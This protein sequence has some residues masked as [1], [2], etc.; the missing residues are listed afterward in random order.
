MRKLALVIAGIG[1][2]FILNGCATQS[3]DPEQLRIYEQNND[4]L[5]PMNRTIFGF[6]MAVDKLV[7]KPAAQGYRA[8][9]PSPVRKGVNNFFNNLKQPVY[10]VNAL[11]QGEGKA[12]GQI[13]GRFAA[14]TFWGFLGVFDTASQM[15]IPVIKRDFGE[16]LAVWGMEYGGPYLVLPVL[17]P[18][19]PRDAVGIGVDSVLAPLDWA[20]RH[21]PWIVYGM[22]GIDGFRAREQALDFLDSLERSST[23]FYATMRSMYQ[24]NRR[25][26]INELLKNPDMPEAVPPYEFDF[27]DDFSDDE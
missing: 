10:F 23:D 9:V 17:G 27:P 8:V 19:N 3:V 13:A 24:Q 25:K 2:L 12:A 20:L 7:L 16:T 6:N 21:E 14:N 26:E 5:E 15:E 1:L 11:L 22:W 18:S 4:P